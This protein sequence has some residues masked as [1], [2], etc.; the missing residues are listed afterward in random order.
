[1]STLK[2]RSYLLYELFTDTYHQAEAQ[3]LTMDY[4]GAC[5]WS[6]LAIILLISAF[7]HA[8]LTRI[9]WYETL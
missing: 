6:V 3:G 4:T 1:M 2:L 7:L 5:W 8:G 9:Q